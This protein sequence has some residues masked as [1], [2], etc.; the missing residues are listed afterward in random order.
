MLY[1]FFVSGTGEVGVAQSIIGV[2]KKRFDIAGDVT[3]LL[4]NL[5]WK[6]KAI[7]RSF[8]GNFSWADLGG[9]LL[10]LGQLILTFVPSTKIWNIVQALWDISSIL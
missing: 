3:R 9:A 10:D 5:I 8:D 4:D 7:Y 2:L 6:L 1:N